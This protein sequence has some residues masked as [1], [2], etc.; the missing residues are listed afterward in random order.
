[1]RI[2]VGA[3]V[4]GVEMKD[5]IREHLSGLGHEVVD[6]G[7]ESGQDVDYPE[8]AEPVARAVANGEV[9]RGVLVCGTGLGMAIVANKVAG[10]RAAPVSDPYSAQRAIMSNNAKVLCLGQFVIGMRLAPIL[11]DHWMAGEF[12]GGDSGRKV[13]K[14]DDL[15]ARERAA[16]TRQG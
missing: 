4:N 14:I 8:T 7:Q 6:F 16:T 9:D 1:M 2:A 3:D 13:A 12:V 11:V 5:L 10:V 15:D